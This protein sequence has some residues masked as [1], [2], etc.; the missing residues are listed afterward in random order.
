V[1]Q[2]ALNVDLSP[3]AAVLSSYAT[4][5]AEHDGMAGGFSSGC[6]WT[7]HPEFSW[8]ASIL[9]GTKAGP[10]TTFSASEKEN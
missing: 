6:R 8:Q 10:R 3:L 9:R 1:N 5:Y 4:S 2:D 7:E